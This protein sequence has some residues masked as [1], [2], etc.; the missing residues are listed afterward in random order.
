MRRADKEVIIYLYWL[1]VPVIIYLYM[2]KCRKQYAADRKV[3]P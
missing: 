3:Q 1:A 2:R